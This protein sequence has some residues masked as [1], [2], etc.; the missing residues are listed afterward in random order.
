MLDLPASTH[1]E[2]I[3]STARLL[4]RKP[5]VIDPAGF[6]REV[7][8]REK[9]SPTAVGNGVAFP[10]ART[11]SVQDIVMAAVRLKTALTFGEGQPPVRL[12]FLIGT[13]NNM[14]REYLGLVGDLA[15][16]VK[17]ESVRNQLLAVAKAAEF[18]AALKAAS[19]V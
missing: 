10:H 13:P 8:A 6:E 11:N 15:R 5:Q 16:R 14:V 2:A 4:A 9:L 7:L 3:A 17:P 12:I 18:L 19:K 1:T